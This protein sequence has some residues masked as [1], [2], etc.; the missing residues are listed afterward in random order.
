MPVLG[1][2]GSLELLLVTVLEKFTVACQIYNERGKISFKITFT[3][4]MIND[5]GGGLPTGLKNVC[6][7]KKSPISRQDTRKGMR[8]IT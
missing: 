4:N 2:S 7:T 3:N 1:I 8:N 5:N 6:Y